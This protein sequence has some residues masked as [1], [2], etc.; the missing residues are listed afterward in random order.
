MIYLVEGCKLCEQRNA[1]SVNSPGFI[2]Y[3]IQGFTEKGNTGSSFISDCKNQDPL[4]QHF[5]TIR[6]AACSEA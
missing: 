1:F 6:I 5:V 4:S 2:Y 3:D